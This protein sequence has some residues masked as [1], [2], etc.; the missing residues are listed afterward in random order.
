MYLTYYF[1]LTDL[2]VYVK[3]VKKQ[4][5]YKFLKIK[6][7][8]KLVNFFVKYL[9]FQLNVVKFSIVCQEYIYSIILG[10]F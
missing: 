10:I 1:S 6:I 4:T 3:V 8:A 7:K 2:K 5:K 9:I